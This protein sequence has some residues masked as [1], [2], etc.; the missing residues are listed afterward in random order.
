MGSFYAEGKTT[1][2]VTKEHFFYYERVQTT[3]EP[4]FYL[5]GKKVNQPKEKTTRRIYPRWERIVIAGFIIGLLFFVC[6]KLVGF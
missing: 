3:K 5:N 2:E 1:V 4:E 6:A